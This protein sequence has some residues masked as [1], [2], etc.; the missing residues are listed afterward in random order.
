MEKGFGTSLLPQVVLI[1]IKPISSCI[2]L[3]MGLVVIW[4]EDSSF[5]QISQIVSGLEVIN[6]VA[7]RSVQFDSDYNEMLTTTKHTSGCITNTL[8]FY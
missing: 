7:E 6:D 8:D 1:S 2:S 4:K 5:Q 3:S